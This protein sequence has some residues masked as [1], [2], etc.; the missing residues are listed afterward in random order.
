[1][2]Q[3]I[4]LPG[5]SLCVQSVYLCFSPLLSIFLWFI[6]RFGPSL[7]MVCNSLFSH[8]QKSYSCN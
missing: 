6:K 8:I 1:M 2:L 4:V 7:V 5:I 3:M